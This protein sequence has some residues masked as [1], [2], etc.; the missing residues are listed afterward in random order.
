[1]GLIP[2]TFKDIAWPI[3][4]VILLPKPLNTFLEVIVRALGIEPKCPTER[5]I[6]RKLDRKIN[7]EI[8]REINREIDREVVVRAWW[9]KSELARFIWGQAGIACTVAAVGVVLSS[10]ALLVTELYSKR[11]ALGCIY[12]AFVLSW[13][14]IGLVPAV[15]HTL[16]SKMRRQREKRMY[17]AVFGNGAVVEEREVE[18]IIS[19]PQVGEEWWIVQLIW[20]IFYIAGTLIV[21]YICFS[22]VLLDMLTLKQYTSIMAVTVIELLAWV[23][24]SAAMNASCKILAF[25]ICL[26][27]DEN[28]RPIRNQSFLLPTRA[29]SLL[30]TARVMAEPDT[31]ELL[32]RRANNVIERRN[33]A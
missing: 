3:R 31:F 5:E 7:R 30:R 22:G 20:V 27:A 21:R 26:R 16:C 1:M 8:D 9:M 28:I 13:F 19:A 29:E 6:D 14:A 2:L 18:A 24:A 4:R 23:L 11:S 12:P 17:K 10:G 32:T 25:S 15:V 33:T